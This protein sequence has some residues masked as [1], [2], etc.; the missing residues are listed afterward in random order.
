MRTRRREIELTEPQLIRDPKL[1]LLP[2]LPRLIER[3]N[4]ASELLR[5]RIAPREDCSV[6]T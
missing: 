1:A 6:G 2:P 3:L 4:G 5:M